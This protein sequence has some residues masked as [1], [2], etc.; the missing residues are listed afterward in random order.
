MQIDLIQ[1]CSSFSILLLSRAAAHRTQLLNCSPLILQ[2][3]GLKTW[4]P[5]NRGRLFSAVWVFQW[6]RPDSTSSSKGRW[7][8]GCRAECTA[9]RWESLLLNTEKWVFFTKLT[10]RGEVWHGEVPADHL[11]LKG[12]LKESSWGQTGLNK[13]NNSLWFLSLQIW[14]YMRGLVKGKKISLL[15]RAKSLQT[16]RRT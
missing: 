10:W 8:V 11:A 15:V 14:E 4:P 1:S 12:S 5:T 6:K 13:D 3:K 2:E 16:C 9:R 7:S